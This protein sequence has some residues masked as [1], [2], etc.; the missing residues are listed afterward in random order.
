MSC[1]GRMHPEA[2]S[3]LKS[4][5]VKVTRR[6]GFTDHGPILQ[7]LRQCIGVRLQVRLASMVR[8]CLPQLTGDELASLGDGCK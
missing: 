7:R 3:V 4:V 2:G 1:Y 6:Q 8:A 5:A